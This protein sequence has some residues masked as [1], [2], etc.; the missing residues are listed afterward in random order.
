MGTNDST[1][2]MNRR[3]F[4]SFTGKASIALISAGGILNLISP[5]KVFSTMKNDAPSALNKYR[6]IH[7]SGIITTKSKKDGL[8]VSSTLTFEDKAYLLNS[9]GSFIWNLCN[10][11]HDFDMM[12]KVLS[13]RYQKNFSEMKIDLNGFIETLKSLNLVNYIN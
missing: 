7:N 4:L 5:D 1:E 3:K 2:K 6:P 9:E 12:S 10:G 11:R 8:I 13:L